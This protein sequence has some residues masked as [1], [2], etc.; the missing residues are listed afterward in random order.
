MALPQNV[1]AEFEAVV[2]KDYISDK[3][4]VIAGH[5]APRPTGW[6][7]KSPLAVLLPGSTEEVAQIVK[8]CNKYDIKYIPVALSCFITAF[9][10]GENTIIICLKRMNKIEEINE[11][12]RY[13][14]I[15]PG[16]RHVHLRPELMKRGLSYTV[17]SVGPGG[18]VLANFSSVSG[19]HHDQH[20]TSRANRYLLGVEWVL[21]DGEVLRVGSLAN[22][23]GYFCP[24]G[25]GPSLRGLVKGF[26]GHKGNMGIITKVA[27]GLDKFHGDKDMEVTGRGAY[28]KTRVSQECSKV[29]V[30]KFKDVE[31]LGKAMLEIGKAEVGFSVLKY[32]YL[33]LGLMM[34]YSSDE[35]KDLWLN[36]DFR[37][38]MGMSL[39]MYLAPWSAEELAYQEKVVLDIMKE[40]EGVPVKEEY[41]KWFDDNMDFFV[42][43]TYLQRVLRLGGGWD[44][45][46]LGADSIPHMVEVA[47]HIPEMYEGL[48]GADKLINS[49]Y[50]YQIIPMEYGHSAHIE[51]LSEWDRTVPGV[52]GYVR[53]LKK[54]STET[55]RALGLHSE[56]PGSSVSS[57]DNMGPLFSNFGVWGKQM[58]AAFDPNGVANP[59]P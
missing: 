53:E 36:T 59:Q 54:R 35:F 4:Y 41:R 29:F 23:S 9:P 38:E 25:P 28:M 26:C 45:I 2:G 49:P 46:K 57:M 56:Q 51:W 34:T 30:Y 42:V 44:G 52:M 20:G 21:P 55:D 15:Q 19:D 50:S 37:E 10:S 22:D 6:T 32:F 48:T 3:E 8:I 16:V 24:D 40:Y 7:P 33:P 14:I 27:I 13:A 43:C 18:S 58:K 5:R 12:D 17:A 1:Y 11:E 47:K 39:V 31:A